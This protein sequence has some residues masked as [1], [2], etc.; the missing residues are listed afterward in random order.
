MI[1]HRHSKLVV[2]A[3]RGIWGIFKMAD[4][5]YSAEVTAKAVSAGQLGLAYLMMDE[6][7]SL[8]LAVQDAMDVKK[9]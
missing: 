1:T 7:Y 2:T 4:G 5:N 3:K 9:F 6:G 8:M